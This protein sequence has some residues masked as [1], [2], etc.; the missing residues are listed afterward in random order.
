M[1]ANSGVWDSEGSEIGDSGVMWVVTDGYG[2]LVEASR[3]AA[4]M[5]NVS[6]TGLRGRQL[7]TFFDGQ[8]ESWRRALRAAMSGLTADCE[9]AVRPREKR[10]R[11][12]NAEISKTRD[13]F[14]R[15]A[16]LW[17]FT[18]PDAHRQGV[19]VE[20]STPSLA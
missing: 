1:V 11:Q 20:H 8:R 14:E 12:I 3:E 5:L 10:P 18:E 13:V 6:S 16:V 2:L 4:A 9:G 15:D 7:L 17:T 19:S